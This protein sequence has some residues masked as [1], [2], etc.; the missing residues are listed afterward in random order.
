MIR[1]L[2]YYS[3][4]QV[5]YGIIETNGK[6][7]VIPT[8]S[9]APLTAHDLNINNPPPQLPHVLISDGKLLKSEMKPLDLTHK[10]LTKI[11]N[12]L[13]LDIKQLIIL[14]LDKTGK[15]Y[16]QIKGDNYKIVDNIF[17]EVSL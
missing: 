15:L 12:F 7:S 3:L 11:L 13:H 14:S 4:D 5:A 6:M 16:Y 2:N 10:Q 9:C 8:S 17:K 1:Q